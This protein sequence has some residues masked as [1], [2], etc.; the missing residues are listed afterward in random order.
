MLNKITCEIVGAT[1]SSPVVSIRSDCLNQVWLTWRQSIRNGKLFNEANLG[2]D[3][4]NKGVAD[5]DENATNKNQ[6]ELCS[7]LIIM[8]LNQIIIIN[9]EEDDHFDQDNDDF[10]SLFLM[11]ILDLHR[12]NLSIFG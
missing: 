6:K 9:D 7:S 8:I 2:C 5:I 11:K 10:K 4:H 3:D 1:P 12:A